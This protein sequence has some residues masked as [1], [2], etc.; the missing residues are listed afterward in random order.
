M[1]GLTNKGDKMK[2]LYTELPLEEQIEEEGIT[3]YGEAIA[4]TFICGNF[5]DGVK[6]LKELNLTAT[7][8]LEFLE[9]VAED[10]GCEL[11]EIYNGHYTADFWIALG[12]EL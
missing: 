1:Y 12:R 11:H 8:L 7:D 6:E 3:T 5:T 9:L 10:Y 2:D 4:Y